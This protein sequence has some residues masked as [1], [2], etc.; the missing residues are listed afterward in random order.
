MLNKSFIESQDAKW[1]GINKRKQ[2]VKCHL[3]DKVR[4][5]GRE[6]ATAPEER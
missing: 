5:G 6:N 1:G 3:A 2:P 4:E